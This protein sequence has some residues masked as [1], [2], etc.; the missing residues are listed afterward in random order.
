MSQDYYQVLGVPRGATFKEL[1][2]ARNF[3]A[4]G[5]HPDRFEPGSKH[6]NLAN[7]KLKAINEAYAVLSNPE[8]RWAYDEKIGQTTAPPPSEPPPPEPPPPQEPP[9]QKPP[10]P[11]KTKSRVSRR[12]ILVGLIAVGVI[13][14]AAY[15]GRGIFSDRSKRPGARAPSE[16]ALVKNTNFLVTTFEGHG[17]NVL[18]M[19]LSPDGQWM[20]SGGDDT[21]LRVW[22]T[23]SGRQLH[24]TGGG[25]DFNR[26]IWWVA[27]APDGDTVACFMQ[28]DNVILRNATTLERRQTLPSQFSAVYCGDFSPDGRRLA[29]G[30]YGK[31]VVLW[32]YP[33]GKILT[34]A[35]HDGQ[36]YGVG[37]SPD[38][39][40]LATA[41]TDTRVRLFDANT[42]ALRLTLT[43]HT[44]IAFSVSF[45]P[46][47]RSLA[48]SSADGTAKL[49]NVSDG[50]LK[51]TLP[52]ARMNLRCLTWLPEGRLLAVGSDDG[53]VHLFETAGG[54][55]RAS[56]KAHDGP[57]R[58]LA[59][60]S[61]AVLFSSGGKT[62]KAWNV[63]RAPAIEA[64]AAR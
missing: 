57:V 30:G 50:G 23:K 52:V 35:A 55:L 18:G 36:V 41:S 39:Q 27:I 26:T 59:S 2:E 40:H 58:N 21:T 45:S 56:W 24:M 42:G 4:A 5:L 37:F 22:D 17:G 1:K 38:S 44:Q 54:T 48:S 25:N 9:P 43:G 62:I 14:G 51:K 20:A 11:A 19:A 13:A 29:S 10:R 60:R 28:N 7:E 32:E 33:A 6:W 63:S 64:K 61:G 31:K 49:W 3:L 15:F 46:D 34:S 47:S 53:R 12:A 16:V 8:K